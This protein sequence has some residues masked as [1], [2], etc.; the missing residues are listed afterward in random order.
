MEGAPTS[1]ILFT[2][3][4]TDEN[5]RLTF[6]AT[7][8]TAAVSMK[9]TTTQYTSR[10]GVLWSAF[11]GAQPTRTA[12]GGVV[13]TV[14]IPRPVDVSAGPYLLDRIAEEANGFP[15]GAYSGQM[16]LILSNPKWVPSLDNDI[17]VA[18]SRKGPCSAEFG[19]CNLHP[20]HTPAP[21]RPNAGGSLV[22]RWVTEFRSV[23]Q[24]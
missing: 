20:L 5:S 13:R 23:F 2:G 21:D 1:L 7:V 11:V 17:F 12:D 14:P 22:S 19:Y 8:G 24:C 18:R 15:P 10:M 9:Y 3:D 4:I 16:Y 6:A